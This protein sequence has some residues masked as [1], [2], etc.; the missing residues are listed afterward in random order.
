MKPL[1]EALKSI[2]LAEA[3]LPV[4]LTD[5]LSAGWC[6]GPASSLLLQGLFGSGWRTDWLPDEVSQHEYEVNDVWISPNGIPGPHDAFLGSLLARAVK[7]ALVGLRA[8]RELEASDCLVAVISL[9]IEE[10]SSV[11]GATVKFLT[12]RSGYP[13]SFDNLERFQFEAMAILDS[14]DASRFDV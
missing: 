9:D 5:L 10:D 14:A 2:R 12:R 13:S 11:N 7:F 6:I 4:E 8:A 1:M 3:E